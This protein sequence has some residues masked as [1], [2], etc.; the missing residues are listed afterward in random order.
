M[1][2]KYYLFRKLLD[3]VA[4]DFDVVDA[5]MDTYCHEMVIKGVQGDTA[6]TVTV[7]IKKEGQEDA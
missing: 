3:M 1:I 4:D 2:D 7:E 5:D 6:V